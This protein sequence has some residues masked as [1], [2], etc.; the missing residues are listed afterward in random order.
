MGETLLDVIIPSGIARVRKQYIS[1]DNNAEKLIV[2]L[3]VYDNILAQENIFSVCN[4]FVNET[5]MR[6]IGVEGSDKELQSV[7]NK[8]SIKELILASEVSAGVLSLLNSESCDIDVFGVDNLNMIAESRKAMTD[9]WATSEVREKVFKVIR[10]LLHKAQNK[11]YP[12]SISRFRRGTLD[13]YG[14]KIALKEI[15]M[16]IQESAQIV[17]MDFDNFPNIKQYINIES[18]EKK[19][20]R[21][22]ADKQ[23]IEFINRLLK[24]LSS[25]Y[26]VVGKNKVNINLEKA[27]PIL[28]YWMESTGQS[29][30]E[31]KRN[32]DRVGIEPVFLGCK[33]WIES[34]IVERIHR[35]ASDRS[36]LFFEEF[37]KLAIRIGV[38]YFDL[39]DFRE[40]V[41]LNRDLENLSNS[42]SNEISECIE[43]LIKRIDNPGSFKFYNIE[44]QFDFL[45]RS[46]RL[47]VP[48][49]EAEFSN[50]EPKLL[51]NLLKDFQDLTEISCPVHIM[52]ELNVF[53]NAI[54][55]VNIFLQ[56]SKSRSKFMIDKILEIMR[57]R[58]ED[59]AILVIGGFHEQ[60]VTR[61]LEDFREISW[62]VMVPS[63]DLKS[64]K[65]HII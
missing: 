61:T 56:L 45:Y 40:Q 24:K 9:L 52:D 60:N 29:E 18:R 15:I 33:E 11:F 49:S 63:L 38:P 46:L 4:L 2:L 30:E 14:E 51:H 47:S 19:F 31:L 32:I 55:A 34:W 37:I 58:N 50:L 13:L 27:M 10:Q 54:G 35:N 42:L 28:I 65:T 7:P 23:K 64:A 25:W 57:E 62:S 36:F 6:L 59:R 41:A 8:T 39:V 3:Q 5:G 12:S 1:W 53:E 48:P 26:K 16:N 44:N 21:N 43:I 20:N 22:R 17:N